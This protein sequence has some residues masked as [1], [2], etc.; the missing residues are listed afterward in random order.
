MAL[1]TTVMAACVMQ[2][3]A[4]EEGRDPEAVRQA[5]T[6]VASR[7][8]QGGDLMIVA[9]VDGLIERFMADLVEIASTTAGDD[10]K[11][12]QGKETVQKLHGF[13]KQNGFYAVNALGM[14][15]V[16]RADGQNVIK[17][18]VS[19][20]ADAA[21]LPLWRAFVG[22]APRELHSLRFM[23]AD[24][25]MA[26]AG[27][28]DIKQLWALIQD[29]VAEVAPPEG[30]AQF[31]QSVAGATAMLGA[32][33]DD[34]VGSI[35]ADSTFGIQFSRESTI[36]VPA[37]A[38]ALSIPSPSMLIAIRV[39]DDTI[40]SLVKRQV[41]S[42]SM[43]LAESQVEG[44]TVY[45]L[46]MPVPVVP[47]QLTLAQH[48][49]FLLVGTTTQVV[50]D[51]IKA[52][53]N[54]GGL[55]AQESYKVAFAG[56]PVKNNGIAYISD[57]FGEIVRDIQK[58]AL[59][60]APAT[61]A[62]AEASR[63]LVRRLVNRQHRYSCAITIMNY[64]SGVRASGTSA[65]GGQQLVASMAIAPAGMIAAIA[66]PSFVRAR[67]AG[68]NAACINNLRQIDAAKEQWALEQMKTNGDA[69][70]VTGV[71]TFLKG[72]TIPTCPKGGVYTL[73][74]IGSAPTCSI[75]G[76]VLP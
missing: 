4:V 3:V 27:T 71:C 25:E 12:R 39:K 26:R 24:T 43:P 64:K 32:S 42:Q 5:F 9:N 1:L 76:H 14:S 70:D 59:A 6:A 10:E 19:R 22:G 62:R 73:N 61:G 11:A 74:P 60:M 49:G 18:F 41:A 65:S 17:T 8:D 37:G 33:I 40:M 38:E 67:T 57:R 56:Q 2:A 31:A 55:L 69:A 51:A 46:N 13:L 68:H 34:L 53:V 48:D 30:A 66:I 36:K 20:D 44:T 63:D 45:S 72:G 23:P 7:L 28:A 54:R 75:P 47:V 16:P 52:Y 58:S 35:G 15:S 29:L 50:T 21:A